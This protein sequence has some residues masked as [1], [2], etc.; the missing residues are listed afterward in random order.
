MRDSAIKF[1]II[2]EGL[3]FCNVHSDTVFIQL[4]FL[5]TGIHFVP[6]RKP[7]GDPISH[8]GI[9]VKIELSQKQL[10]DRLQVPT[11]P[12]NR[13][14]EDENCDSQTNNATN[15]ESTNIANE[16]HHK[17]KKLMQQQAVTVDVH[18]DS[19]HSSSSD[20]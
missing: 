17:S 11:S 15:L 19:V 4:Q 16:V 3:Q 18:L 9:F 14:M 10:S 13:P 7:G 8:I 20:C 1:L 6:L 2:I 12:H 5:L